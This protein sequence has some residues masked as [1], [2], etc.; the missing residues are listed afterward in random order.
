M[1][2]VKVKMLDLAWGFGPLMLLVF[3]LGVAS[4]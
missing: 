2:R 4:C 1:D 3:L